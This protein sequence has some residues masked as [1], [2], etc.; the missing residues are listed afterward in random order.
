MRN[1]TG[2]AIIENIQIVLLQRSKYVQVGPSDR[3]SSTKLFSSLLGSGISLR[4][5][6]EGGRVHNAFVEDE[7]VV[8]GLGSH[9]QLFGGWVSGEVAGAP[10]RDLTAFF[11]TTLDLVEEVSSQDGVVELLGATDIEGE[12]THFTA[13]L[14]ILGLVSVVLGTSRSEVHD[15]IVA[16]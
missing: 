15:M 4:V 3:Y 1:K 7:S 16:L 10:H 13:H 12:S 14:S 11:Q 2:N 9:F 5:R 6:L 8:F